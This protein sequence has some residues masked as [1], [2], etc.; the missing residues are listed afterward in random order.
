[1]TDLTLTPAE[2]LAIPRF[3][4]CAATVNCLADFQTLV[5]QELPL[6][7]PHRILVCG[8][9]YITVENT[10]HTFRILNF[11]FPMEYLQAIRTP[12]GGISSPVMQNWIK[13]GKPQLYA[14]EA[15]SAGLPEEWR[16][17]FEHYKLNNLAAHGLIDRQQ[18]QMSYF[19]F[20]DMPSPLTA[21]QGFLLEILIPPLHA[22]LLRVIQEAPQLGI[23]PSASAPNL[24]ERELQL[25]GYLAAG[26]H[27]SAIAGSMGIS[28]HTVRNHLRSL[29]L[30]LGVNKSTQA[31][32]KAKRLHLLKAI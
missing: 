26:N 13:A 11:G 30:K 12:D 6:L 24:T 16:R 22:A 20:C 4:Q 14:A 7:F 28:E 2:G 3:L 29:Y 10:V 19:N 15:M 8:L 5:R 32:E 1:M 27:Q 23:E 31:I 9:G 18:R 21:H 17:R 25:L